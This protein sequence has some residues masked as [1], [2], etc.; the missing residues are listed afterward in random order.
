[1]DSMLVIISDTLVVQWG[2]FKDRVLETM[3]VIFLD[4]MVVQ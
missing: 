2:M 3:L 4:T 1:M